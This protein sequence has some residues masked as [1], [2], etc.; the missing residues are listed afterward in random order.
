MDKRP[1][2]GRESLNKAD[3]LLKSLKYG[4]ISLSEF[5]KAFQDVLDSDIDTAGQIATGLKRRR[6]NFSG[7][8][9]AIRLCLIAS[10]HE[11]QSNHKLAIKWTRDALDFCRQV[12]YRQGVHKCLRI[13]FSSNVHLGRY[14]KARFFAGQALSDPELPPNERVKIHLNLGGIAYRMHDYAPALE[15]LQRTLG[16]LS[17]DGESRTTAV[18]RYN[19]GLLYVALNKYGEA[20]Q[21]FSKARELFS[22]MGHDLYQAHVLQSY[23]FLYMILGQFFRA[24]EMLQEA[25]NAYERGGDVTGAALC[26]LELIRLDARLNR[27]ARITERIPELGEAFRRNG[28]TSELGQIYY[29][30]MLAAL[31]QEEYDISEY[32]LKE[33]MRI[34]RKEKSR[35]YLALCMMNEGVLLWKQAM[36]KEGLQKIYKAR[37]IFAETNMSE[38]E[39]ECYIY[40]D[41]I[42]RDVDDDKHFARIRYLLKQPMSLNMRMQGLILLHYFWMARHQVKRA[43][44]ALFEAVNIVEES[45]AS[46]RSRSTRATF[47]EDKATIYEMLIERLL[48]WGHAS[49]FKMIFRVLEMSRSRQMME[50][51]RRREDL[52]PVINEGEPLILEMHRLDLHLKQLARKMARLSEDAHASDIEKATLVSDMEETRSQIEAVQE[53][54]RNEERL[55]LFYPVE[56]DPEDIRKNMDDDQ[57]MVLY[58]VG[59]KT[60]YRMELDKTSLKTYQHPLPEHFKRDLNVMMSILANRITPRMHAALEIARKLSLILAPRK[61]AKV[62]Q[63]TFVLHKALQRFPLALLQKDG[64]FLIESY[65]INQVPNL[66]VYY[67]TQ[68]EDAPPMKRPTFFFSDDP[69]DPR[70]PERSYLL[71]KYPDAKVLDILESGA[72]AKALEHSDFIHFAGHCVFD[73]RNP[74]DSYLQLGGTK[75]SLNQFARFRLDGNPF[76]NLAACQSGWM[77]LGAGNEPHGFVIGSFAAG[78]ATLLASLWEIDDEATG[79]WMETFYKSIHLGIAVAYRDACLKCMAENYDPYLWAGFCLQGH[80]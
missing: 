17:E 6:F 9:E 77:V 35:H 78:A 34:F 58:F 63:I 5:E 48:E 19:L 45:R 53:Q 11:A 67:Y 59:Q 56:F 29:Q 66:G 72:M 55:S 57:L 80:A 50:A 31:A 62:R 15:H 8:N 64:K 32:Y 38:L 69:E 4:E 49:A 51:L 70:A 21:Y 40:S 74:D 10:F 71:E 14:T 41:R 76:L 24:E 44:S 25:L 13:L 7:E 47:F 52:P 75:L 2:A 26:E 37:E 39:L 28:R 65:L 3:H 42:R 61:T 22:E 1:G 46:I 43:I 73:R 20:E 30:G 23:G 54:M 12:G 36:K 60:L 16:L 18:V 33:A 79:V 68:Q 27:F